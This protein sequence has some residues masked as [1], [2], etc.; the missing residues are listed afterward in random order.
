MFD[1]QRPCARRYM[2]DLLN[3]IAS[4]E[5]TM[6]SA[7]RKSAPLRFAHSVI[8]IVPVLALMSCPQMARADEVAS[9]HK[10]EQ[11]KFRDLADTK[12]YVLRDGEIALRARSNI[13]WV[14]AE[15]TEVAAVPEISIGLPNRFQLSVAE[16]AVHT[17]EGSSEDAGAGGWR[18]AAVF[19]EGRWAV[20]PWGQLPLNPTLG[21]G[22]EFVNADADVVKSSLFLGETIAERWLWAGS[23]TYQQQLGG[24]DEVELVG[25]SGVHYLVIPDKLTLGVEAKFEAAW[26][27][28]PDTKTATEFLIG[29]ALM[30]QPIENVTLK[31]GSF[32]GT[33]RDSPDNETSILVELR[34]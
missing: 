14:P 8:P 26:T 17:S 22:Y 2:I 1:A 24:V 3:N 5:P 15:S 10:T 12:F 34:F 13:T 19:A 18:H 11:P 21:F 32:F 4:E 16:E 9:G 33:T 6:N 7:T 30:W 31:A 20:A 29:P 27:N 28:E 25:K 23:F